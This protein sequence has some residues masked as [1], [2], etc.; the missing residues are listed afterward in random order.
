MTKPDESQRGNTMRIKSAQ[1]TKSEELVFEMKLSHNH[2]GA[3]WTATDALIWAAMLER[4][5]KLEPPREMPPCQK[6]N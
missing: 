3:A 5:A 4:A 6:W 1:F 2:C